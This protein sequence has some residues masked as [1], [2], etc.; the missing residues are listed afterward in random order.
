[1]SEFRTFAA[2]ALAVLVAA[3]ATPAPAQNFP[4]HPVKIVV[5][6]RRAGWPIMRL[7]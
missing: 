2:G 1:M 3:A 4:D 5:H 6:I 7:A